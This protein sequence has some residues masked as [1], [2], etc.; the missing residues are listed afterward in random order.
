MNKFKILLI[1]LLIVSSLISFYFISSM[2]NFE[3][4]AKDCFNNGG[5]CM[6]E[7]CEDIDMQNHV[8]GVCPKIKGK[9]Y[10][11]GMQ[12]CCIRKWS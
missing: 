8:D 4:K 2:G 6:P 11:E 9:T 1:I 3:A 10:E 12:Y 7:L 5:E